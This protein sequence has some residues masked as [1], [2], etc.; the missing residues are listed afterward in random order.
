MKEIWNWLVK[1]F[2]NLFTI[3]GIVLTIYFSIFYVPD[4]IRENED[5]KIKNINQDLIE[6]VQEIIYN[7]YKINHNQIEALI[8]GKE[9]KHRVVYPYSPDELLI[10]TQ[11]IFM[12]NKFIPLI[13]RVTVVNRIDSLRTTFKP[14][15]T[16]TNKAKSEKN[17]SLDKIEF[18]TVLLS[19]LMGVTTALL[20]S[21]SF[22]TKLR[23]ERRE[24]IK[25]KVE[26]EKE[27][28]ENR[29]I[30]GINFE[31]S[32]EEILRKN[33]LSYRSTDGPRDLG[34][35]F[36]ILLN[37]SSRVAISVKYINNRNALNMSSIDKLFYPFRKVNYPG[38]IIINQADNRLI[39]YLNRFSE[40]LEGR[41]KLIVSSELE[42]IES[43]LLKHINDYRQQHL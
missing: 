25:D 14:V 29:I 37:E 16:D 35:D 28:I 31:K 34:F 2:S 40:K 8:K 4:Y 26:S 12:A 9:I 19:I 39:H 30:K 7:K 11:E 24:S 20:G 3:I 1:N 42:E 38:I 13:E 43:L 41:L 23:K 22:L 27:D 17:F 21:F 33:N 36:L 15:K 10:Q 32:I 6:S 18:I 5:E